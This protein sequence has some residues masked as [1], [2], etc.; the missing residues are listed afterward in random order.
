M[1]ETGAVKEKGKVEGM[2]R[3]FA[4]MA[5]I[6]AL[7]WTGLL[8]GMAL[9]YGGVTVMGVKIFGPLHGWAFI[10]YVVVTVLAAVRL[11]WQIGRAHV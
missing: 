5:F 7:T 11:R 10:A 3:V 2:G 4:V 9:K 8:V 6:E 1:Q